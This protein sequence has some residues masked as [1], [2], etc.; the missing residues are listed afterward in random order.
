MGHS[1]P[2]VDPKDNQT[3]GL[4]YGKGCTALG[5]YFIKRGEKVTSKREGL[6]NKVGGDRY[7]REWKTNTH[8]V[9]TEGGVKKKTAE[10][11]DLKLPVKG[12][13]R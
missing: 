12:V 6:H 1:R 8:K 4:S 9:R 11:P 13:L 5:R 10:T 3:Q 2:E 7:N